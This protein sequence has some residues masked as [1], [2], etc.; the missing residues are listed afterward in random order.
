[1]QDIVNQ[2][3]Y[4]TVPVICVD[5]KVAN[6]KYPN[7]KKQIDIAAFYLLQYLLIIVYFK[8]APL[9]QGRLSKWVS[10]YCW[11]VTHFFA[12]F[13]PFSH[14]LTKFGCFNPFFAIING[15]QHPR[16]WILANSHLF[17]CFCIFFLLLGQFWAFWYFWGFSGVWGVLGVL[18]S[19]KIKSSSYGGLPKKMFF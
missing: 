17:F 6:N 13:D 19:N 9:K 14:S 11:K 5:S 8:W 4:E 10:S 2:N 12:M 3:I 16:E 15:Y 18:V 1:M 7:H